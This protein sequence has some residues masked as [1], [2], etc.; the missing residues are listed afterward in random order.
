MKIDHS[1][2]QASGSEKR[3]RLLWVVIC[4]MGMLLLTMFVYVM[5]SGTLLPDR[6]AGPDGPQ[7]SMAAGEAS[8]SRLDGQLVWI[9]RFA[10]ADD[11]SR[12]ALTPHVSDAGTVF[13]LTR[14][15]EYCYF[16]ARGRNPDLVIRYVRERPDHLPRDIPWFGGFV[17]P[18]DGAIFDRLG[19]GLLLNPAGAAPRLAH[20]AVTNQPASQ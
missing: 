17:D 9:L 16:D 4:L 12:D 18:T 7:N 2:N 19:R 6:N 20:T 5:V 11:I 8:L 13:C 14:E 15:Q 10:E 3:R 1:V